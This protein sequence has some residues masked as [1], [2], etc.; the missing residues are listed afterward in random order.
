[1]KIHKYMKPSAIFLSKVQC[2]KFLM[3][4]TMLFP[5]SSMTDTCMTLF[6]LCHLMLKSWRTQPRYKIWCL[7]FCKCLKWKQCCVLNQDLCAH[8]FINIQFNLLSF[9]QLIKCSV[10]KVAR[11]FLPALTEKQSLISG[12]AAIH[13]SYRKVESAVYWFVELTKHFPKLPTKLIGHSQEEM[14]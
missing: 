12:I 7:A 6:A 5:M 14:V 8:Y 13:L 4:W 3:L 11:E 2:R 1:M 10:D 9:L